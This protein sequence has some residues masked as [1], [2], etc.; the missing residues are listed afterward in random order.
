MKK[1]ILALLLVLALAIPMLPLSGIIMGAN[2]QADIISLK[3]DIES[4]Y[5]LLYMGYNEQSRK[6][7]ADRIERAEAVAYSALYN[8]MYVTA[9]KEELTNAVN[10]LQSMNAF[11]VIDINGF[12]AWNEDDLPFMT[13][14]VGTLSFDPIVKPSSADFSVKVT[15][16][17]QGAALSNG[18]SSTVVGDSPFGK[19]ML[20]A[21]G[22]KLWISVENKTSFDISIGVKGEN[23]SIFTISDVVV[24]EAGEVWLPFDMFK[25]DTDA[26]IPKDGSLNY[27]RIVNNLGSSFAVSELYAYNEILETGKKTQYSETPVTSRADLENK[28][29]YKIIEPSTGKAITL[30]PEVSETV[31]KWGESGGRNIGLEDPN[32][33]YYLDENRA[34]DRTQMWQISSAPGNDDTFVIVNKSSSIAMTISSAGTALQVKELNFDNKG[35]RFSINISAGKATIQVR[36]LAKLT[37]AGSTVKVTSN[38]SFKKF[39]LYKVVETEYVQSW[40]D[41]FD[42][43]ELDRTKWNVVD[44][45]SDGAVYPDDDELISVENGNLV[46]TSKTERYDAY[47]LFGTYMNTSGKFAFGYGKIEVRA[48][49]AYGTGQFPAFWLMPTDMMNM[50][51]GEV[52]ILEM[53]VKGDIANNGDIIGTVH[54]TNDEGTEDWAKVHYLHIYDYGNATLSEDYHTFGLEM[55]RDQI[56]YYYDG[57]QYMSLL[58]NTDGKKFAFGDTA[59][60]IIFNNTPRGETDNGAGNIVNES[61]GVEDEYKIQ[62]DYI[63]VFLESGEMTQDTVD[64]TTDESINLSAGLDSVAVNGYWD[65]NFPTDVKP[66]G[67]E[68]ASVDHL[69]KL[70]IFDPVTNVTKK[71]VNINPLSDAL[72]VSY[73]PDGS[74]LAIATTKGCI[75][76]YDTSDYDKTPVY[77]YNG[78]VIQEN[79]I[80]SKDSK[81]LIVGGF[82]GGSQA[83]RNPVNGSVTEKWCFRVFDVETGNK[84]QEINVGSDPRYIALSDDGTMLA[85]TTTSNGVF[86]YNTADWSEIVHFEEGHTGAIRGADFSSDGKLLVTSDDK[87]AVNIWDL[88]ANVLL[89]PMNNVNTGSV[90]RVIFSPDDKNILCSSTYGAARL[91]DVASGELISLL[92]GFGNVVRDAAYSPDGKHIVVASYEGGIKVFSSNG[93]YLESL[94][95]GKYDVNKEGFI[96]SGIRFSPD[97]KYVF[98]AT[99]TYP[100]C[101]HKWELPGEVDKTLLNNAIASAAPSSEGYEYAVKVAGLKYASK[102]TVSKA[103]YDLVGG[104]ESIDTATVSADGY[105]FSAAAEIYKNGVVYLKSILS[106]ECTSLAVKI[107]NITDGTS[108]ILLLDSATLLYE[109]LSDDY[110]SI[111]RLAKIYI[112]NGGQYAVGLIDT[113]NGIE[114]ATVNV[115]VD[116]TKT[117]TDD[118]LYEVVDGEVTITHGISGESKVVIPEELEGYPVT[119]IGPY[120]FVGY[121]RTVK[122]MDVVLPSTLKRIGDYAFSGCSSL[123]RI[124]FPDSLEYIGSYAFGDCMLLGEIVLPDGVTLASAALKQAGIGTVT[125]GSDVTFNS[126]NI[127]N[128]NY[129]VREL[130]IKDG[131]E[132]AN[133]LLGTQRL[134]ESIYIPESVTSLNQTIFSGNK[135]IVKVY[136]VSGSYAE[137]Y[138]TQYPTKYEFVPLAAPVISG[139]E[140][141]ATYDLYT[142]EGELLPDWDVG[143][144]ATLNGEKYRKGTEITEPGEYTLKVVNG[145]DEYSTEITFTVVDTTPPPYKLGEM[146]GDGVITVA[147]A[148]AVLRIVAKLAE[149]VGNQALAADVDIDGEITVA[150]ALAVLRYV[151]KLS[152]SL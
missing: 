15:A 86:L 138:A 36:G 133:V 136:G 102:D 125:V 118:F 135:K 49:L 48:K 25:A 65:M 52:D 8:E 22:I 99:R 97:S 5:H 34:G 10:S 66:D 112:N 150:D 139:V 144:I 114:Y 95:A 81:Q 30:G 117:T 58:Y 51:A 143:P 29:Y 39:E 20:K 109:E 152:D 85:V 131:V 19:D 7:L 6:Y 94:K 110:S 119:A 61:W 33:S 79:L 107:T 111:E 146:D 9:A 101:L 126:S 27:I 67:S 104:A 63:R 68:V 123:R 106:P 60:Y 4:A 88:E 142:L 80:F 121:G 129:R 72:R 115:S 35:Q 140:D 14:S 130:I 151:A 56:R 82:N 74:R 32:L 17:E 103:Y 24:N 45:Y 149:P 21:D 1:K 76:I 89:R 87:G 122:A 3:A 78:A 116:G 54:W 93:T 128:N 46:S 23:P 12:S 90:R 40:S 64:Y 105:S 96:I 120:A 83:Y 42:G 11:E 59:R 147:D 98:C 44:G 50:G 26:V 57:I 18:N 124:Q 127:F 70:Y 91:F 141:G 108:D 2:A 47:E 134:M 28:A 41:E 13:E 53:S 16:N 137:E 84:L 38:N 31:L 62:V 145:Y 71:I 100:N 75:A 73:S 77:I 92:G 113:A 69:K 148:L 37:S 43:N 132:T 55:D